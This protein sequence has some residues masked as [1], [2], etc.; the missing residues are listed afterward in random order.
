MF[1]Y[2]VFSWTQI[3]VGARVK[4]AAAEWTESEI[5]NPLRIQKRR[6]TPLQI[7][8]KTPYILLESTETY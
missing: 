2:F 5:A 8:L 3:E 7:R 1:D 4:C 6:M